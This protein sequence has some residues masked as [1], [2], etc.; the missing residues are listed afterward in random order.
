MDAKPQL[1]S[2]FYCNIRREMRKN[3]DQGLHGFE[4]APPNMTQHQINTGVT[5]FFAWS[6]KYIYFLTDIW[7]YNRGYNPYTEYRTWYALNSLPIRPITGTCPRIIF[8]VGSESI[9][10][11]ETLQGTDEIETF[12][13]TS[14]ER[15]EKVQSLLDAFPPSEYTTDEIE[16]RHNIR[17]E[18]HK[19]GNRRLHGLEIAPRN[20]TQ[21]K[22]DAGVTPFFA[23][24]YTHIYFMRSIH[25]IYY[26]I[27]STSIFEYALDSIPRHP[28]TRTFPR[29]L[30]GYTY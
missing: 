27:N 18:M 22:I 30:E 15:I 21:Q 6:E 10:E 13:G 16:F 2:Q 29:T 12:Q 25:G 5:P 26:G 4:I 23:W 19:N 17:S 3:G 7:D 8:K 20:I 24:S 1:D 28:G 11:I 9:N 14:D